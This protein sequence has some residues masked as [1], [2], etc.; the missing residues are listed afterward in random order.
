MGYH[1]LFFFSEVIKLEDKTARSIPERRAHK[2]VTGVATRKEAGIWKKVANVIFA[3]SLEDA[4]KTI[5][6]DLV[7][8]T[9]KRMLLSSFETMLYGGYSNRS[10]RDD[11]SKVYTD[12]G[13]R[14]NDR[15]QQ[16]D[17]NRYSSG[18]RDLYDVGTITVPT[19]GEAELVLDQLNDII[20]QYGAARVADLCE[21]VDI[22]SSPTDNNYGWRDIRNAR[23]TPG[24]D[25]FVIR[26]PRAVSL[27]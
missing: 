5:F 10:Y 7:V 19:R 17:R 1:S 27:N 25:G 26:L 14:F 3:D 21:A 8:P 22:P 11:R 23:I 20:N 16:S 4:G 12:Y 9:F 18:A 6:Y 2:V 24:P 15:P 13:S